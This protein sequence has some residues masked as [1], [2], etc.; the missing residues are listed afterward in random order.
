MAF[1]EKVNDFAKSTAD[2]AND[3]I[4]ISKLNS[5]IANEQSQ[6]RDFVRELGE[7]YWQLISA[8]TV[9][10]APEAEEICKKLELA[11]ANIAGFE[12]EIAAI[13]EAAEKRKAELE[14]K[15]AA[16]AAA[17]ASAAAPAGPV[18]CPNCGNALPGTAKFCP[19]CGIKAPEPKPEPAPEPVMNRYCP[20]CGAQLDPEAR[21]CGECGTKVE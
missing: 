2:K 5:K 12:A 11:A 3:S 13:H 8:K 21:F 19:E 10:P 16:E 17:A 4:E 7:V 6:M 18:I 20:N 9:A 1:F 15:Q 14:A